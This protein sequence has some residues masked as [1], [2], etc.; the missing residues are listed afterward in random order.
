MKLLTAL[1]AL[2]V[3]QSGPAPTAEPAPA[4][5][6]GAAAPAPQAKP[7]QS[8]E[9]PG[10]ARGDAAPKAAPAMER[11][12]PATGPPTAPQPEAAVPARPEATPSPGP[13]PPERKGKEAS[14]PSP[15][16]PPAPSRTSPQTPDRVQVAAAARRFAEALVARRASDVA[17][18][19]ASPFSFDGR[20]DSNPESVRARWE[21]IFA[22]RHAIADVL[23]DL[24]VMTAAEAQARLGK[25]PKRIAGLLTPVS[26]VAV[27]DLSGRAV[28][29]I[30][31]RQNG[32]F[33]ATAIH[34]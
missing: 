18:L 12:P 33:V 34:G 15:T 25:P 21:Q 32:R 29:I 24:V 1:L 8:E 30:F 14:Q 23:F 4:E 3:S 6:T 19:C 5:S 11:E 26:W 10:S 13:A 31:A 17:L 2:A 28:L 16:P 7:P 9:E 22:A 27:A 20:P